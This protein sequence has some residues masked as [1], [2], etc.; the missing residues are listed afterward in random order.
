MCILNDNSSF[1]DPFENADSDQI[2]NNDEEKEK[3]AA[4]RSQ[5]TNLAIL[6]AFLSVPIVKLLLNIDYINLDKSTFI[7]NSIQKCLAP[8]LTTITN[9]GTVREVI[10]Q[11][12]NIFRQNIANN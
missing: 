10:M 6:F 9:F 4:I 5:Q 11:Y 7:L 12:W 8:I 1:R 2:A 3:N